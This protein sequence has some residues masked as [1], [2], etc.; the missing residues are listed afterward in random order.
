MVLTLNVVGLTTL[1]IDDPSPQLAGPGLQGFRP[2]P[3]MCSDPPMR[4]SKV[5]VSWWS[6]C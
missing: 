2:D 4:L 5:A 6:V 1:D 3:Q